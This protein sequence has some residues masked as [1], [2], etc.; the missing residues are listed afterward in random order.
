MTDQ[1]ILVNKF[2]TVFGAQY[3]KCHQ[4]LDGPNVVMAFSLDVFG[5]C[6]QAQYCS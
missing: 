5:V 4:G 2:Q 1:I 6:L 3:G